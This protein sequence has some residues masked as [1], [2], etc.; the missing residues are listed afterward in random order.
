MNTNQSVYS[1]GLFFFVRGRFLFHGCSLDKAENYGNFLVYSESHMDVWCREYIRKYRVDF[2]Y[3]PRGRV[4]YRKSDSTFLIYYDRC[5]GAWIRE[6]LDMYR[7]CNTALSFDEHY[8]CHRC[9]RFY[10][11]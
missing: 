1:V 10:V 2:D 6:I 4:V 8:Q 9:N 5:I 3:F 11:I 7:N